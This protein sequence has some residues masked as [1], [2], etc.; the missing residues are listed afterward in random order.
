MARLAQRRVGVCGPSLG[1][2]EGDPGE[3][4]SPAAGGQ[5][6]GHV[7]DLGLTE[8]REA[9]RL[10]LRAHQARVEDRIGDTLLLTEHL[11][12]YTLGRTARAEHAGEGWTCG[13]LAGIPVH[14]SDRGGSI[15]YHG[16]GQMV[17]YPILKLRDYCAGPKAYVAGLE[18][19]V[20][21]ALAGLGVPAGRRGGMPGVWV[22]ER[23]IAAVG[24]RISRGVTR[25]GFALNVVNDLRPFSAIVPCGLAGYGV[26]SVAQERGAAA[27]F[28]QARRAV[29]RAFQEV[30]G[31]ALAEARATEVFAHTQA[32]AADAP[33][34]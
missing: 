19:T 2:S 27:D 4:S 33:C 8:Y 1:G 23:K 17:G 30:F 16:P 13:A 32:E 26:T 20:I 14:A 10:Q 9:C 25:H 31:L 24:V 5:V 28:E 21:R 22:S 12:V 15:T 7:L 11:P 6:I 18:E 34:V 3:N 29:L